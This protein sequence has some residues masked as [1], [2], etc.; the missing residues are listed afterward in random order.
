VLFSTPLWYANSIHFRAEALA[1]L[2]RAVGTPRFYV[3]DTVGMTDID[4]TGC[5]ALGEFLDELDHRSITL[6][7]SRAGEHLRASLAKAGLLA[8][9]GES[10]FFATVDEAVSA[11]S[12]TA[13][14]A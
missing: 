8:R 4:Y 1:A 6:A 13:P 10:R 12:P 14:P 7:V 2:D 5:R 11:L 3:L 9:I